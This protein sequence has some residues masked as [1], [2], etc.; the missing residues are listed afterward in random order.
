MADYSVVDG[1]LDGTSGDA[2]HS[3]L[4]AKDWEFSAHEFLPMVL[5]DTAQLDT[6]DYDWDSIM[7]YSSPIGGAVRNG[8]PANVYTRASDGK[9]ITYN[10]SPS[11]RDVNRF[12]AMYSSKAPYPNPCLINEG[13]S[14]KQA[15]FLRIKA[16]C[17]R[18]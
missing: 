17:K 11:Q 18:K 4:K 1:R 12:N 7:L 3:Q 15:M 5:S 10:K 9:V 13:C 16:T 2:C 14:P 8:V 6:G